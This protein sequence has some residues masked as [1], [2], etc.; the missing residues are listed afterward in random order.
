M[1]AAGATGGMGRETDGEGLA[2]LTK[3]SP[4]AGTMTGGAPEH[5]S[6]ARV[7]VVIETPRG[8]RLKYKF[9]E[10]LRVTTLKSVLPA[11]MVFPFNFGFVPGT[12]GGDGDPL[13]VLLLTEE[14]LFPGCV[15]VCR[16]LG[17][18]AVEQTVDGQVQRNDRLLAVPEA[19]DVYGS[20][21]SLDDLPAPL[22]TQVDAFFVQ[23]HKL[24]GKTSRTLARLSAAESQELLAEAISRFNAKSRI[25]RV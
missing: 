20:F 4:M 19:L 6:E 17:A 21:G 2:D 25:R 5:E 11:G 8:S 23:Y 22:L 9:D 16:L 14:P 18:M 3:L 13:D 15:A 10:D 12:L 7:R 1:K 24:G